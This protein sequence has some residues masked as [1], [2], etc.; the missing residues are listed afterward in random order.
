MEKRVAKLK[1]KDVTAASKEF[2]KQVA[3]E[4]L[5]KSREVRNWINFWTNLNQLDDIYSAI[6][7]LSLPNTS[8]YYIKYIQRI[9]KRRRIEPSDKVKSLLL[10]DVGL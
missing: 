2:E 7:D 9:Q 5:K 10:L 8:E 6:K 1:D 3:D 4:F